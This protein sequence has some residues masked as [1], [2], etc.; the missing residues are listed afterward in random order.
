MTRLRRLPRRPWKL[1]AQLV[2]AMTAVVSLSVI[3]MIGGMALGVLENLVAGYLS[4]GY[5]DAVAFVV[6]VLVLLF[7]PNGLAGKTSAVRV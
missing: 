6:L 7:R 2:A 3:I 5:R 4:S 1:S